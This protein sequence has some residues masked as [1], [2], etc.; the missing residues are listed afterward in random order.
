MKKDILLFKL[1]CFCFGLSAFSMI[2]SFFGDYKGDRLAVTFAVLTGLLFWFGLILGA[3]LLFIVNQHRKK[4]VSNRR[5]LAKKRIGAIH[6]LSNQWAA[7][8]DITLLGSFVLM[9]AVMFI[10]GVGQSIATVLFSFLLF[11]IYMHCVLNGINFIY[12][13]SINEECKK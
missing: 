6:F 10:P 1:A 2:L 3:V 4:Y 7:I 9:L 12:I 5:T 11:A 8:A 13:K